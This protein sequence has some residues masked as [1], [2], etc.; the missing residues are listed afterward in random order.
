MRRALQAVCICLALV[1][2]TAICGCNSTK[3]A[4]DYRE[5]EIII[6]RG[7]ELWR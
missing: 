6:D 3:A 5:S 7:R 4:A 1:L 2:L